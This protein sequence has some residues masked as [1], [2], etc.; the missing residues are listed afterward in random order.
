VPCPYDRETW[1]G[2]MGG[3]KPGTYIGEVWRGSFRDAATGL[4]RTARNGGATGAGT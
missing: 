4:E 3:L 1:A 2:K